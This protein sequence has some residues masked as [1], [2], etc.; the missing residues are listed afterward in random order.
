MDSLGRYA[1]DELLGTS[2][3]LRVVRFL[4]SQATRPSSAPEIATATGLTGQGV[5]NALQRLVGLG[6]VVRTGGGRTQLY[7]FRDDEALQSALRRLFDV[8]RARQDGL[9]RDLRSAFAGIAGVRTA[10]VKSWP[11][12]AREPLEVGV[13]ADADF[14]AEVRVSSRAAVAPLEAKYDLVVEVSQSTSVDAPAVDARSVTLL[15]GLPPGSGN[16]RVAPRVTGQQRAERVSRAIAEQLKQDPALRMRARNHIDW[17]LQEDQG[18]A[19]QDLLEWRQI[20]D[21]YSDERLFDFVRSSS[22]RADRL[23]Q[24]SPFVPALTPLQMDW[25][26]ARVEE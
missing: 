20:L 19:T 2:A 16:A 12:A 13:V 10:W 8:E 24:S 26:L 23:N 21:T 17:L 22:P 7:A 9:I 11:S 4:T 18:A 1:L 25:L 6:Y 14:M 5:R 3:Q 15:V